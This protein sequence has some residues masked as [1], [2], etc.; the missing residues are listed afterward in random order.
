MK[1]LKINTQEQTPFFSSDFHLL[2]KNIIKYD[3]R[4]FNDID[5]MRQALI[6]NWNQ[7]VKEND[8]V[9]YLGDLSFKKFNKKVRETVESLNGKIHFIL[10]NHD[11]EHAVFNH[12]HLFESIDYYKEITIIDGQNSQH[13]ILCHYPILSW[14]RKHK[15]SWHLHGHCHGSLYQ[16]PMGKEYYKGKVIDVG[17]NIHNHQP[18]SYNQVK[19]IMDK[20]EINS[21]DHHQ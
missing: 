14:H 10:G 20:K 21:F 15:G 11:N 19:N 5:H 17:C 18:L 8:V 13:V 3:N 16:S 12:G 6:E 2:H 4:P 9:F 1:K 7:V